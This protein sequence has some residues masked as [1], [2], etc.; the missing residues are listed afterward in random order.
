MSVIILKIKGSEL[1]FFDNFAYSTQIDSGSSSISFSSFQDLETFGYVK[2]EAYKDEVL[3]FTGEV[4]NKNIPESIPPKPF[5]YK[6]ESLP[7]I[8][9]ES[10]LPVTAY[11]LQ[12]ENSTLKDIVEYICSFFDVTV[13]FDQSAETEAGSTY[14]ISNL[15]FTKKAGELIND[16]VTNTGA[17][18][19]HNSLGQLIITNSIEQ[20]ELLLPRYISNNKSFDLKKFFHNYI[21]L[22]QAPIGN[23][24]DIQAIATFENIDSR[25]NITKIQ[26]SG[27]IDA[28]EKKA[29]GMRSDSLK[30]IQH[31][32]SFDNFFCNVGDFIKLGDLKLIINKLDYSYNAS[33]E[34]A[35][36]SLI[37]S[38][39]YER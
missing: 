5:I 4:I 28:I 9:F 22:G 20:S 35:S 38:Q 37:D 13:L 34:K 10:T 26:N 6:A 24:A 39:I 21:A 19:T 17:I 8:L 11:P 16:L 3:I 31:N 36:I 27:G 29:I 23:D 2:I 32:L 18:L 30:S 33:G 14:E 15:D 1:K 25:R 12:L 7:H